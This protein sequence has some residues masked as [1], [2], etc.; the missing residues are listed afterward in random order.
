MIT[1]KYY[2]VFQIKMKPTTSNLLWNKEGILLANNYNRADKN[3]LNVTFSV[4]LSSTFAQMLLI[5]F[6]VAYRY[7]FRLASRVWRVRFPRVTP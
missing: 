6:L 4:Y 1:I 5:V 7:H 2:S 3:I